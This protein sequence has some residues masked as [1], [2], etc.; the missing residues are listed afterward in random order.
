MK[1]PSVR[2]SLP[3]RS[4]VPV[5]GVLVVAAALFGYRL[6]SLAPRLSPMEQQLFDGSKGLAGLSQNPLFFGPKLFFWLAHFAPNSLHVQALRMPSVLAGIAAI[7]LMFYVLHR[8]YGARG[9]VFGLAMFLASAWMLHISRFAGF[10]VFYVLAML[11]LFAVYI[12]L[13]DHDESAVMWLIWLVTNILLLFVPGMVWFVLL[14]AAWQWRSL[15]NAW[16]TTNL[17]QRIASGLLVLVS[18]ASLAYAFVRTPV[19]VMTWLGLPSHLSALTTFHWSV[20]HTLSALVY[21]G[22]HHPEQWLG[23]LPLLD[24]ATLLLFVA[25]IAFY[26]IHWRANRT[27]LLGGFLL[28]GIILASFGVIGISLIIPIIYVVAVGGLAY[29]THFWMRT[30]PRNPIARA[31][32]VCVVAAVVGL[33]CYYNLLQYFVA[34]PHNPE[35]TYVYRGTR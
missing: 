23:T 24:I 19:L 27:H 3:W 26:G 8:W 30:F 14:G 15:W 1:L 11:G 10:D 9:T 33:S 31:F 12:A 4:I 29:V 32:G 25:G 20:L 28:L 34:W 5:A 2:L 21:A 6:A 22:P 13:Y 18:L 35:T 7:G 16:G 17:T